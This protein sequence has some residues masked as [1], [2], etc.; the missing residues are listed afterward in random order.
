MCPGNDYSDFTCNDIDPSTI[1]PAAPC[2]ADADCKVA[3]STCDDVGNG[4]NGRKTCKSPDNEIGGSCTADSCSRW[5]AT[6]NG[7]SVCVCSDDTMDCAGGEVPENPDA[8]SGLHV[9]ATGFECSMDG[10]VGLVQKLMNVALAGLSILRQIG[11][12]FLPHDLRKA[13]EYAWLGLLGAGSWIG[14][15]LAAAY[16]AAEEFE[17]GEQFCMIMGYVA[18]VLGY[19]NEA[20][21]LLD[22]LRDMIPV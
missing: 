2:I 4:R 17:Y 14:Y 18:L 3:G 15:A 8:P 21:N 10:Y 19:A 1:A 12:S 13:V 7:D 11:S 5:D 22:T 16:F 20:V 6:C 9:S